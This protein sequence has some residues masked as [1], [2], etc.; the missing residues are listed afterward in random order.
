M[1]KISF[2]FKNFLIRILR[3]EIFIFLFFIILTIAYHFYQDSH[4]Y[5]NNG[6]FPLNFQGISAF[7]L[8]L[9]YGFFFFL[10]LFFP[11]IFL[12]QLFFG[13]KFKILN[14]SGI[15]MMFFLTILYFASVISVFSLYSIKQHQNYVTRQ[16]F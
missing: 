1:N 12:I 4:K 16:Q 13:I 9:F 6:D 10:I 3:I 11:F 2:F 14:K 5:F 7:V 8:T 15:V